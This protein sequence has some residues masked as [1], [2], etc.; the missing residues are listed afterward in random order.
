MRAL[1]LCL[2]RAY[3]SSSS[4]TILAI[5]VFIEN[6]TGLSEVCSFTVVK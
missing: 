3:R 5:V 4:V 1:H 2:V 6:E